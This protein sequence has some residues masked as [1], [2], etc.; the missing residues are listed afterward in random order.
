M[1]RKKGN[2]KGRIR[3]NGYGE[4]RERMWYGLEEK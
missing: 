2:G 4:D 1:G 3:G